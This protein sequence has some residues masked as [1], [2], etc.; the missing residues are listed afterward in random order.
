MGN[1]NS[2]PVAT[3]HIPKTLYELNY[4]S[5]RALRPSAV[6]PGFSTSLTIASWD[7]PHNLTGP[8]WVSVFDYLV[9]KDK[10]HQK[11]DLSISLSL[12]ICAHGIWQP[13][14][15]V[16]QT[17]TCFLKEPGQSTPEV[18]CLAYLIFLNITHAAIYW[19]IL[20]P[21]RFQV[22]RGHQDLEIQHTGQNTQHW[23]QHSC[24]NM[25]R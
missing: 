2:S 1:P 19:G 24:V 18:L 7:Q 23:M 20:P 10:G 22:I 3:I 11:L 15:A 12:G 4:T 16:Y 9:A 13:K 6:L 14:R 21:L 17:S 8:G 25:K 5:W